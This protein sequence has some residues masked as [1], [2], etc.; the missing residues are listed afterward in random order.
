MASTGPGFAPWT[1]TTGILSAASLPAGTSIAPTAFCPRCAVAVPTVNGACGAAVRSV[2]V[3][4]KRQSANPAGILVRIAGLLRSVISGKLIPSNH[5][6]RKDTKTL[7]GYREPS[8]AA[9][10]GTIL[11]LYTAEVLWNSCNPREAFEGSDDVEDLAR[12]DGY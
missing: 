1:T 5:K 11:F 6:A 7:S 2:P 4:A 3:N 8:V 12:Y 9:S 10:P